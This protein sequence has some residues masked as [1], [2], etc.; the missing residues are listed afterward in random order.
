MIR[1]NEELGGLVNSY[2]RNKWQNQ[3]AYYLFYA[4]KVKTSGKHFEYLGYT[5][6]VEK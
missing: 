3:A 5:D 6:S 4:E 1:D 2:L